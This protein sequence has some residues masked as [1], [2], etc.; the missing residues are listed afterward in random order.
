MNPAIPQPIAT[1]KP[2]SCAAVLYIVS[3]SFI[4]LVEGNNTGN[5]EAKEEVIPP[6]I[7]SIE[8]IKL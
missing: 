1:D 7:N 3:D 6:R 5:I 8:K 4:P 2:Y